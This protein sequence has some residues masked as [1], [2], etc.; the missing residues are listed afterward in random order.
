MLLKDSYRWLFDALP[1]DLFYNQTR[2]MIEAVGSN[3]V[4]IFS[5]LQGNTPADEQAL[6]A[7]AK[8]HGFTLTEF[9][10]L[11]DSLI[12]TLLLDSAQSTHQPA[13]GNTAEA[14]PAE[15]TTPASATLA[16]TTDSAPAIGK[17][18]KPTQPPQPRNKQADQ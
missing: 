17:P 9:K 13:A 11:K 12:W 5:P 18:L 4:R 3:G 16:A 8:Q 10:P 7:S 14:L 15:T 6:R 2:A 1:D